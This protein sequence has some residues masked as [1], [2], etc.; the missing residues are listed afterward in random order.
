[1]IFEK[2]SELIA[3]HMGIEKQDIEPES[4]FKDDFAADSLD[5]YELVMTIEEEYNITISEAQAAEVVTV[6]D[7]VKLLKELGVEE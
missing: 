4:A 1:M 7:M 3:E 5:L 6:E 2:L